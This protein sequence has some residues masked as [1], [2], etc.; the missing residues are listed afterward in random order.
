MPHALK[1]AAVL[2]LND[3]ASARQMAQEAEAFGYYSIAAEDHFFMAGM[4]GHDR[5]L[6]RLE[7]FTL[8]RALAPLT[9]RVILS[10]IVAANSFRHPALT[11][12]II[13]SLHQISGGRVELGI[14]AGW[15][16]EE[17]DALGIDY[18][19]PSVRIAQLDEA[20]HVI[21]RLWTD[22]AASFEGKYYRISNAPHAPKPSPLPRILLGGGGEKLLRVAAAHADVVNIIPPAGGMYGRVVMEENLKFDM[23]A[24]EKRATFLRDECA[25]IGRASEAVELSSMVYVMLGQTEEQAQTF[26][27]MLA[28]TMGVSDTHA[29]YRSPNTLVG[30][31]EQ[32]ADEIRRRRDEM[33]VTYYFCNFL[34]PDMFSQFGRDVMPRVL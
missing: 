16:R 15:F 23:S 11:A 30:T 32:I 8:L 26:V 22:D 3:F 20:L 5:A 2:P 12:K 34:A 7:C 24:F 27:S 14:G 28:A 1:F 31:P 10:Q 29:V 18:P 6:P 25:R 17:Y 19:K 21:K 9:S 33:G 13:S 4:M